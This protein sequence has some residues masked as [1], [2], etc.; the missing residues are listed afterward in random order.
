MSE[1][2]YGILSQIGEFLEVESAN[3]SISKYLEKNFASIE[4]RVKAARIVLDF[5][6]YFAS[7]RDVIPLREIIYQTLLE[8]LNRAK[9]LE[10][11]NDILLIDILLRIIEIY[12]INSQLTDKKKI[13]ATL[14]R[15]LLGLAPSALIINLCTIVKPI[16]SQSNYTNN[17]ETKKENIEDKD[18]NIVKQIKLKIENWIKNLGLQ[19]NDL[20]AIEDSK[21]ELN[22]KV[23][24][25]AHE[26]KLSEK[27]SEFNQILMDAQD[28]LDITLTAIS[29]A[30]DNKNRDL[31]SQLFPS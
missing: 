14:S 26:F 11:L 7:F 30:T 3:S 31:Y 24:Y 8:S 9:N 19:Q 12:I 25:Y 16:F 10:E 21:K 29:L 20:K 13:I 22:K 6:L 28:L 27:S 18:D 17:Y 23:S 5:I 2:Y 1:K 4:E 15:S